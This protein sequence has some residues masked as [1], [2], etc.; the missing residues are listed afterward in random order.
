MRSSAAPLRLPPNAG[1]PGRAYLGPFLKSSAFMPNRWPRASLPA[2]ICCLLGGAAT[3]QRAA[4]APVVPRHAT[5]QTGP[6]AG[7]L[8]VAI[9]PATA[10]AAERPPDSATKSPFSIPTPLFLLNTS[11]IVG[12]NF[13]S[14]I[15]PQEIRS[16][17]VY[18]G[19]ADTPAKWRSLAGNGIVDLI[20]KARVKSET[21]AQ[22]G[23]RLNLAGPIS[24]RVNDLP[25]RDDKL[26]IA[27][28]AIAEIQIV[29]ATPASPGA[30]VSIRTVTLPH[31]PKNDP[32]GTIYIRGT[33]AR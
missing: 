5:V 13:L 10:P 25:V 18:K 19:G 32:P 2:L 9:Q 21:F 12:D 11:I 30:V 33:A 14:G 31:E 8:G 22:L 29:W 20:V 28:D 17:M 4:I 16:L 6:P 24:Y 1:W 23:R 26:R 27:T 15:K 3:A 7:S